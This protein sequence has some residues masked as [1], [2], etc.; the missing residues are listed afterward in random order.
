MKHFSVIRVVES[1]LPLCSSST[2]SIRKISESILLVRKN[3]NLLKLFH[4]YFYKSVYNIVY[5]ES[6]FYKSVNPSYI[7]L[8]AF[9]ILALNYFS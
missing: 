9:H 5:E 3:Q 8:L 4:K 7:L 1:R 2:V 6:D